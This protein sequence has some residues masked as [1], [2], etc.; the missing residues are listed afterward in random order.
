MPARRSPCQRPRRPASPRLAF[1]PGPAAP[2]TLSASSPRAAPGAGRRG[3]E[4]GTHRRGVWGGGA[5]LLAPG[6]LFANGPERHVQVASHSGGG[7]GAGDPD[8]TAGERGSRGGARS[9]RTGSESA[10]PSP[11]FVSRPGAG[12]PSRPP[13]AL[14]GSLARPSAPAWVFPA[15]A[16]SFPRA[17]PPTSPSPG[18]GAPSSSPPS[19]STPRPPPPRLFSGFHFPLLPQSQWEGGGGDL[20]VLRGCPPRPALLAPSRERR[21]DSHE[22]GG[23]TRPAQDRESGVGS[24]G[25]F[26]NSAPTPTLLDQ[27]RAGVGVGGM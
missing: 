2:H 8:G 5:W 23:R 13:P 24:T 10:A 3:K 15:A 22:S 14:L 17:L 26:Y 27:L 19:C 9:G 20:Q 7:G 11:S 18:A 12:A 25:G 1:Q 16:A 6:R 4:E 21:M